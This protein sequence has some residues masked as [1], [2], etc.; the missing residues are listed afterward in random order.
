MPPAPG[1]RTM[2]RIR[3]MLTYQ[4]PTGVA[5]MSAL[6]RAPAP[7]PADLPSIAADKTHELALDL[8]TIRAENARLVG[9]IGSLQ[10]NGRSLAAEAFERRFLI[11][12]ERHDDLTGIGGLC[13]PDDHSV[14]VED[15]GLD[16]R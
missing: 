6:S 14:A 3:S 16:H 12:D 7:H 4:S 1:L 9:G 15:A 10:R 13:L 2:S 8:H 11:V 5:R